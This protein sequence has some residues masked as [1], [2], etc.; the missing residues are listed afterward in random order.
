MFGHSS[1]DE[2]DDDENGKEDSGRRNYLKKTNQN[3]RT[4]NREAGV[5]NDASDDENLQ[6]CKVYC[7]IL[8]Y[9]A[10]A[11]NCVAKLCIIFFCW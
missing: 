8:S 6:F 2:D 11:H 3:P 1:E 7:W 5:L 9:Q 10:R 4:G